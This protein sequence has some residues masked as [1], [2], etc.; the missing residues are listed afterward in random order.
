[1]EKPKIADVCPQKVELDVIGDEILMREMVRNLIENAV[2]H[3]GP[4]VEV[5]CRA[6]DGADGPILEVE[7]NGP[8]ISAADR[9]GMLQRFARGRT[10]NLGSGIGLAVVNEVST[11]FGGTVSIAEPPGGQGVIVRV[12]LQ[13]A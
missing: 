5:T 4:G 3:G 9:A 1:M 13:S 6:L 2:V 10:D 11:L 8:G 12:G 7:D